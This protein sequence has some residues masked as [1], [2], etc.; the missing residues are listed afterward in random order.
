M[1]LAEIP[2]PHI[3]PG[4]LLVNNRFS[5]IS[6]GTENLMRSFAKR[7][8]M[9]KAKSRPDLLEQVLDF[10][11]TEGYLEALKQAI[12]RLDRPAPLGYSSSGV[13]SDVAEEVKTFTVGDRVAC[14]GSGHASH[15]EFAAVPEPMVAKVPEDL[16][17]R[18]AS[19]TGLGATALHSVRLADCS[20]GDAVAVVG[21][22][23][24]G[25]L[26]VQVCRAMNLRVVAIDIRRDR[27]DLAHD[28]GCEAGAVVPS[29]D[30]ATLTRNYTA[31]DGFDA[32][33]VFAASRD[34]EPVKLAASLA[35]PGAMIVVPGYV[36]LMLPRETF[37]QKELRLVVPRGMGPG[38]YE[39][40]QPY[41]SGA[42]SAE[43][44][45]A[46]RNMETFLD[47]LARGEVRVE[48]LITR[49]V[50]FSEARTVYASLT[51]NRDAVAIVFE[52]NEENRVER[53]RQAAG[54][55][56]GPRRKRGQPPIATIGVIG[57][58]QFALGTLLPILR[59][60]P[61]TNLVGVAAA[62]G[63]SA[64]YAA[65]K[66]G[67]RYATT[68]AY[69]ILEDEDIEAIVIA[70][71]HDTHAEFTAQALRRGKYTFVEKPLALNRKQ[72]E[73]VAGSLK[74]AESKLLVGF[75]RRFSPLSVQAKAW[76]AKDAW[77]VHVSC[78]VNAPPLSTESWVYDPSQGGG[79]ILGE[80]CHFVD[81]VAYFADSL[82]REVSAKSLAQDGD[83]DE[84]NANFRLSFPDG[85]I[86]VITYLTVGSQKAV[87][88]SVEVVGG[89]KLCEIEN[90]RRLRVY[91]P[92]GRRSRWKLNVDRGHVAEI[93]H[94]VDNAAQGKPIEPQ[95]AVP[96]A[97]TMA[98]IRAREALLQGET[99]PIEIPQSWS[100]RT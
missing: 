32:V 70:T 26:A 83:V 41:G 75:N 53:L 97:V 3:P 79:R 78:H 54:S 82:M 100:T 86:G 7:S 60:L 66:F 34:S 11:R 80:V 31:D 74:A 6:T 20:P 63:S 95:P 9:G 90:F 48:P 24:L 29:D 99:L 30:V 35:R 19:F 22:G 59:R 76:M 2:L 49:V 47:L 42:P 73:L 98:T 52:Y 65:R 5:V 16:P 37:Y 10:A 27:I 92:T 89:G 18:D 96:L 43:E 13:V 17:L 38:M 51:K 94:F 64:S 87:R 1:D 44:W 21:V 91:G 45:T 67:F 46:Q 71:R 40:G 57:A 62:S 81:L 39:Q 85:S 15:S 55:H 88:E 56:G 69:E 33:I 84:D 61:A 12:A 25:L 77:P 50:P 14:A 8:L 72:L 4:Y 23:L 28:L 93:A 36:K 58:G 68:D